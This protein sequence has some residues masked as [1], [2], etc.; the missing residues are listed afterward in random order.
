MD[1]VLLQPFLHAKGG[2]EKVVLKIAQKYNA[3]IY[4]YRYLKESTFPEF[5]DIDIRVVKPFITSPASVLPSRLKWGI[6]SGEVFWNIKIKDDYDV[7][8]AHGTPSEWAR[9]R[10]ERML[11]YCHTPN[12]EAFDLYEWRMKQRG[13]IGKVLFWSSIQAYKFFEFRV[14]DKIEGIATNSINSQARIKKY[15]NR[16]AT[17]IYPGIDASEYSNKGYEKFF[18]YPSRIT[19]EKRFELAIDAFMKSGLQK[20]GYKLVIAGSLIQDRKEHVEYYK[21]ICGLIKGIGDVRVNITQ[22]ELIDLYSRCMAVV[23][24][25]INEDFGIVPLEAMASEKPVIAINEGGPTETVVH[26]KT[27]Y[28]CNSVE[29]ISACMALLHNDPSLKERLGKE[30]KK[31]VREKFSWSAFFTKFDA[32]AKEVAKHAQKK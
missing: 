27:G 7:V 8:N 1:L 17:V 22:E 32:L 11:W 26:E 31:V 24:T 14:V 6:Q 12:R 9:N 2:L 20:Q 23:F 10:N 18:L 15:L 16:N 25:P 19:P 30:G 13:L 29:E 21:K 3:V 28:L 4:T 5:G